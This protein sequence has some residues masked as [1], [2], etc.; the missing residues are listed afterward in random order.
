[1]I[2]T[3]TLFD[4]RG[5]I[6][7]E[8]AFGR[9]MRGSERAARRWSAEQVA[10]VDS[11][12]EQAAIS[13]LEFTADQV[14]QLLPQD[15]PV[16]KGLAARLNAARNRGWIESTGRVAFA[17]RGGE[18]DHRQRLAVWRSLLYVEERDAG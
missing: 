12:I 3:P 2:E 13:N 11:A 4:E 1:M 8:I 16:T 6:H 9:G 18:H 15:F 5:Q 7:D 10:Q 14:W 17:Q